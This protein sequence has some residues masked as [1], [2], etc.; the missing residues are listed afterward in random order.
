[1]DNRYIVMHF[2]NGNRNL[3]IGKGCD[4]RMTEKP[5]GLDAASYD[6][7]LG[8]YNYSDGARVER[9]YTAPRP[10]AVTFKYTGRGDTVSIRD[11]VVRFFNPKTPGRLIVNYGGVRRY[12]EYE[13]LS[14]KDNQNNLHERLAF[15]IELTC[16]D[17]YFKRLEE[18]EAIVATW[19]GGW[20]W[21]WRF[22]I[23][24][25]T[26]G[27]MRK[28]I[29]NEGDVSAPVRIEFRGPATNPKIIHHGTGQFVKINETITEND[30]IYIGSTEYEDNTMVE[31]SRNGGPREDAFDRIDLDSEL[32]DLTPG[33][34]DIE[35]TCDD[36]EITA[37]SV[38]ISFRKRFLAT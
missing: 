10:I 18:D 38:K 27:D 33:G 2:I 24:F 26:R 11:Q 28:I 4:F 23:K 14:L 36:A 16:P 32:F 8:E 3:N 19:I 21:R 22:P 30:M 29:D 35:F 34:N 12:I 6:L 7:K 17:P 20:K 25:R 31:L 9:R 15:H 5:T 37:Q 1:M 13:V